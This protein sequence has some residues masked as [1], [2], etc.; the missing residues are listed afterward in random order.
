[1][2][3]LVSRTH[4]IGQLLRNDTAIARAVARF[5]QAGLVDGTGHPI[6]GEGASVARVVPEGTTRVGD[7]SDR[8]PGLPNLRTGHA[9]RIDARGPQLSR[10]RP[11]PDGAPEQR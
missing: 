10:R 2:I 8:S 3:D 1:A 9:S 7:E 6:G 11:P 4:P 5:A